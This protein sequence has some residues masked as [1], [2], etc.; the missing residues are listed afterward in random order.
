MKKL[1]KYHETYLVIIIIFLSF[2]I[3]S[4]N[5][6]FM[7]AEN[8]FD[9]LKSNSFIGILAIGTLLVLI[10]G[11]IDISFAAI[12]TVSQYVMALVIINIGGNIFTALMVAVLVGTILGMM[13][14]VLVYNFRIP[15]II[16]TIA[17]MNI[18]YGLLIVFT[19]GKWIYSLPDWFRN[20]A[21]IRLLTFHTS[22]GLPYGLSVVTFIWILIIIAAV[23]ILN[24][25]L[26]G[27]SIYALGGD[28]KSC[29]RIGFNIFFTETFVYSFMGLVAG[30]AGVVQALLIQT[31]AP[32]AIVGK[33]LDV[34]AAVVLGGASLT[35]GKGSIFGALLGVALLAILRNGMT[36]MAVPAVWFE[37]LVGIV[38]IVS[39]GFSSYQQKLKSHKT[40]IIETAD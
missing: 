6:N 23:V 2:I 21:E 33:E 25:T 39:V 22:G 31:I 37:F 7:T 18:Y 34:I 1:F 30:I 15:S 40:S 29:L 32:N 12:A 35:G 13:N 20:F 8:M 28:R 17:T 9:L 14:G 3:T 26:L 24:Y 16:A 10:S 19:G 11:G 27:R 36:L 38:I 5:S 4:V